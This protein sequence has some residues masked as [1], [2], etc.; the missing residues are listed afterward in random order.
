MLRDQG[1]RAVMTV[2]VAVAGALAIESRVDVAVGG[3][4]LL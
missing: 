2:S 3:L 1:L 4:I